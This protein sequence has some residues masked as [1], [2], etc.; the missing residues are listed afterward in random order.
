MQRGP[1]AC[2]EREG[3]A[4]H[5]QGAGQRGVE[6]MLPVA[7]E[8]DLL[9]PPRVE[10]G[11]GQAGGWRGQQVMQDGQGH[12]ATISRFRSQGQDSGGPAAATL[13]RTRPRSAAASAAR[14][15]ASTRP[16][17]LKTAI[18][19]ATPVRAGARFRPRSACRPH[20]TSAALSAPTTPHP[21][22]NASG[23]RM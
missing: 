4:V 6:G 23:L 22:H 12:T 7:G 9:R 8:C 16:C 21:I 2:H 18:D 10:L 1:I 11:L 15:P 5:G 3:R 20:W 14:C 17:A 19:H 13:V